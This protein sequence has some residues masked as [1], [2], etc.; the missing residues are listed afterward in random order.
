MKPRSLIKKV[1]FWTSP[2]RNLH[3][4]SSYLDVCLNYILLETHR[5]L[6]GQRCRWQVGRGE[7]EWLHRGGGIFYPTGKGSHRRET[8]KEKEE[9]SC[10]SHKVCE[11]LQAVQMLKE[12][13]VAKCQRIPNGQKW[14]KCH[15]WGQSEKR[16]LEKLIEVKL[17]KILNDNKYLVWFIGSLTQHVIF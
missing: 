7:W 3:F 15:F 14:L 9:Q 11:V 12:L 17:S 13:K 1:F 10:E 4:V 6:F 5:E 16:K 8:G 2:W